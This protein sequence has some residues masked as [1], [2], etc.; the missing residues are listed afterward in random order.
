MNGIGSRFTSPTPSANVRR[1]KSHQAETV[2][3]IAAAAM[4]V[5][6]LTY[7]FCRNSIG[8]NLGLS[9]RATDGLMTFLGVVV[10]MRILEVFSALQPHHGPE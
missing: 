8:S 6:G 5:V 4:G 7:L 1:L 9:V 2:G 10:M 3:R